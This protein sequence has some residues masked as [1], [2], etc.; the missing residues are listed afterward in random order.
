MGHSALYQKGLGVLTREPGLFELCELAVNHP[1]LELK[2]AGFIR[3]WRYR[4]QPTGEWLREVS[5]ADCPCDNEVVHAQHI[6][7]L[8]IAEEFLS[9]PGSFE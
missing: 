9:D 5:S 8:H 6:N 1:G 4:K 3:G 7:A 2:A